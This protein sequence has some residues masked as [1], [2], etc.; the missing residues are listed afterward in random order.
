MMSCCQEDLKSSQT[1]L[2][3]NPQD[4][5]VMAVDASSINQALG[6]TLFVIRNDYSKI[7]GFFSFKLKIHQIAWLQCEHE[8]VAIVSAVQRSS[9]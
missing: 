2:I 3:L 6:A 9:P 5:I 7:G 4:K 1:I 8:T